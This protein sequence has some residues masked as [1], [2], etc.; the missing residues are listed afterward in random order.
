MILLL[1][2]CLSRRVP[3]EPHV[4]VFSRLLHTFCV[5]TTKTYTVPLDPHMVFVFNNYNTFYV[6]TTDKPRLFTAVAFFY[7]IFSKQ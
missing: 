7:Y 5:A 1:L 6:L 4:V 2:F 3:L